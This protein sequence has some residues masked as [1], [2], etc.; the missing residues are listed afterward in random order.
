[1]KSFHFKKIEVDCECELDPQLCDSAS[2][3]EFMLTPVSLPSLDPITEPTMIPIPID[4]KTEPPIL[5][6][7][8]PLMDHECELKFFDLEPT[9]ESKL[10]LE[11]KFDLSHIPESV[12]VPVLF[13]L[14]YKSIILPTHI[15]LLDQ[16]VDHYDSEMIFQDWSYNWDDFCARIIHD[17]IQSM[18]CKNI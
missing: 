8:I 10:T 17:P 5:D 2:I 4:L 13:I 6:S 14:E 16:G 7:H 11:P 1:M 3:F 15:P 18:G 9:I 12:L